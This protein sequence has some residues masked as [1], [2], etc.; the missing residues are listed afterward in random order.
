MP[1]PAA[2]AAAAG[3]AGVS[4][5]SALVS[6]QRSIWAGSIPLSVRLAPSDC[7]TYDQADPYLIHVPRLS[8]LPFLLGRLH[9]F[10]RAQLI[11][12][13]VEPHAA[14]FEFDGVALKWHYPVGLLYDL[15]SG[16]QPV[17]PEDLG[18]LGGVAGWGAVAGDGG[19]EETGTE[20]VVGGVKEDGGGLSLLP[21][22]L[23][24][25]YTDFPAEQLVRLDGQGKVLLD[26][27]RN[28]VKEADF[29]RNGTGKAVM[30]LSMDDFN[31]LWHAVETHNLSLF[32]TVN[33]KLLNPPGQA[34][35]HMPMKVYLPT[36]PVSSA[37]AEATA[38]PAPAPATSESTPTLP[39]PSSNSNTSSR[40]TA[41]I[42]VV[43]HLVP[44][45]PPPPPP[46]PPPPGSARQQPVTLGAA[47]N[48]ML[49][50]VFPSRRNPVLACA[51][52]HG[53]I[54]PLAAPVEELGRAAAFAD[55]W[56]HVAVVML[57]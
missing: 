42:R 34:L 43:Q 6:L 55:G 19:E 44:L 53:A 57:G 29:V 5:A 13:A 47:L 24:L 25:H 3:S 26:A 48:A 41:S 46:P 33:A 27:F 7:R 35:R 21:W 18:E 30:S 8:Y 9:A 2:A 32:N 23:T 10:F 1:P 50:S 12:P 11:D 52:M 4:S 38:A 22:R 28:A 31:A 15:F 37:T 45:L 40:P 16:A 20:T 49:P 17:C 39:Q 56:L 36:A 51:A 54:V 14:W